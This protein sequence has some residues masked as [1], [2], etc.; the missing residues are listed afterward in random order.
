MYTILVCDDDK[1]IVDAIQIYLNTEGYN[2]LKAYNG[3]EALQMVENNEVHLI[4]LDVMMPMMDGMRAT[5]KLRESNSILPIIFL[6]AK[7][8]DSDKVLGLNIGADDYI[9]KPFNP[10]ELIARVK[11]AL[12]RYTE[13]GSINEKTNIYSSGGLVIDDEAKEVTVDGE[14]IKLTP[15]EYNLLKLLVKNKGKVFSISEI[16]EQIWNEPSFGV[17]NIVAVHIRH[18]REKIE[19][20]SKDPKYLKVA[21]GIGYKVEK[22]D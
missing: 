5:R 21:W 13:L 10:L 12:R 2:V 7:S 1:E 3:Y 8:E 20:N 18:I 4:L 19:I 22:Y 11:S 15:I 17:D 9:T 16:Y 6:T 14:L